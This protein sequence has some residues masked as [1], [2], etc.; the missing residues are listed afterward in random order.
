MIPA[1]S[2]VLLAL[3][4]VVLALMTLF[5]RSLLWPMVATDAGIAVI[6]GIDALLALRPLVRVK[7]A[8]R[9]V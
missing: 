4:P 7:R 3:V 1:R 6:A 9:D 8:T 2:L 5:D